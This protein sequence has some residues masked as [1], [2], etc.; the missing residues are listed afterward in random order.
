MSGESNE[1]QTAI[2]SRGECTGI[3]SR[4]WD[5]INGLDARVRQQEQAQAETRV[6]LRQIKDGL[7]DL[8]KGQLTKEEI[9]S[10]M[11]DQAAQNN[12]TWTDVFKVSADTVSTIVKLTIGALLYYLFTGKGGGKV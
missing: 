3:H 4:I 7:D 6:M 11:S 8:K 10:I 5:A 9:V 1:P 2:V 12:K